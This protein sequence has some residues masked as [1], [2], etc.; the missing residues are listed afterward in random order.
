MVDAR[1]QQKAV[2]PVE[3][4]FICAITPG[5]AVARAQV[6]GIGDASDAALPFNCRYPLTKYTLAAAS[7]NNRLPLRLMQR[8]IVF[9]RI[10]NVVLPCRYFAHRL[11]ISHVR[12]YPALRN[13]H[14]MP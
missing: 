14:A 6:F 1:C 10:S 5:L 12:V 13:T 8:G 11:V 7:L 9:N 3:P 4:L 2:F